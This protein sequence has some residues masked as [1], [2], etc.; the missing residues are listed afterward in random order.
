[1]APFARPAQSGN[2]TDSAKTAAP[3]KASITII[4]QEPIDSLTTNYVYDRCGRLKAV[5]RASDAG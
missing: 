2:L 1:L 3:P 5:C 4:A